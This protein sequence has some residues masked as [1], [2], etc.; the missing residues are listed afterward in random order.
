MLEVQQFPLISLLSL[1]F[2]IYKKKEL[3]TE[4]TAENYLNFLAW[5]INFLGNGD[6]KQDLRPIPCNLPRRC[7][8]LANANFP[9]INGFCI[10]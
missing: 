4:N 3:P 6:R 5:P 10:F 2:N 7:P 9:G 1:S 8:L